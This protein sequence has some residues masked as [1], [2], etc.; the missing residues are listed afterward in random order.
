MSQQLGL[1]G[2]KWRPA[3]LMPFNSPVLTLIAH[4]ND[5]TRQKL[6][7]ARRIE[8][9][10]ALG[11]AGPDLSHDWNVVGW[12][13]DDL[14]I[15]ILSAQAEAAV[16]KPL[17]WQDLDGVDIA[18]DGLGGVYTFDKVKSKLSYE[19]LD[20]HWIPCRDG[21]YKLAAQVRHDERIRNQIA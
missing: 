21:N 9:G 10:V 18:H 13:D 8:D 4:T 5:A 16:P 19:S 12:L 14:E 7:M 15:N 17:Q 11:H 3:D 2:Q 20:K 6:V 1:A